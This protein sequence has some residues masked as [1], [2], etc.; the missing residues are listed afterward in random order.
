MFIK[1]K[2]AVASIGKWFSKPAAFNENCYDAIISGDISVNA[3]F[4]LVHSTLKLECLRFSG[5]YVNGA[6]DSGL[7]LTSGSHEIKKIHVGTLIISDSVLVTDEIYC[8][9]IILRKDACIKGASITYST[10]AVDPS[11]HMFNC[12]LHCMKENTN[13]Q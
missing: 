7:I 1:L 2:S 10:I 13:E 11:V 4:D 8:N 6:L 5:E 12:K 9:T 3:S